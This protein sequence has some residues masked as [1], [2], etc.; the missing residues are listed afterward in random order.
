MP[1]E[2]IRYQVGEQDGGEFGPVTGSLTLESETVRTAALPVNVSEASKQAFHEYHTALFRLV[3]T[4]LPAP[5]RISVWKRW[6]EDDPPIIRIFRKKQ[7]SAGELVAKYVGL[8]SILERPQFQHYSLEALLGLRFLVVGNLKNAGLEAGRR[9]DKSRNASH[10]I[11]QRGLC[12][13][14]KFDF[15]INRL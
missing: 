4:E 2:A 5:R 3:G 7:M 12:R 1:E 6:S 9:V 14:L 13:S 8:W 15:I 10:D 11:T